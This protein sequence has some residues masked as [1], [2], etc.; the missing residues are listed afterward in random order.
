MTTP[1]GIVKGRLEDD[2]LPRLLHQLFLAQATG[3]LKLSAR[4]SESIVYL[5]SGYPVAVTLPGSAELLG[6]VLYEMKFIDEANYRR[7]VARPLPQGRRYGQIVLEEK[8][9]TDEQLRLGLKAQVRRKLHRLFFVSDGEFLFEE[10][11]HSEGMEK[12]TSLQINPARAIYQGVRSAWNVERLRGALFLIRDRAIR[13]ILDGEDA[14]VPY[15]LGAEDGKI[16]KLLQVGHWRLPDLIEA[17]GLPSQVVYALVYA[18]YITDALETRVASEVN[19]LTKQTVAPALLPS[20]DPASNSPEA[21][22]SDQPTE[23]TLLPP[24]AEE[25]RQQLEARAKVIES[26]NLFEVL[27]LDP[28]ASKSQVKSAYFEA[29]KRFHPDR[30]ISM[31]LASIRPEVEK[32]FHR[33][34]EAYGTLHDDR[35]R[36]EYKRTLSG[37]TEPVVADSLEEAL[38]MQQGERRKEDTRGLFDR[39]RKR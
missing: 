26:E 13:T 5:R 14:L 28:S 2:P 36:E 33:V 10:Q 12:Q 9:I 34:S 31:G 6:K 17:A 38:Q 20:Q 19:C 1:L 7:T 11:N 29:A 32:I 18:L 22:R 15:G 25:V 39:F 37:T 16:G 3:L 27:G 4:G 21:E 30:L 35:R 8:L 24:T 23:K